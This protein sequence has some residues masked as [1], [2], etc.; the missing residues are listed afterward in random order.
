M[1]KKISKTAVLILVLVGVLLGL[2]WAQKSTQAKKQGWLGIY[3]QELTPELKE[4]MDLK[5]STQG[6]LV[7]GV[8]EDSPAEKAGLE[9]GDVIVSFDG[10]KTRTVETLTSLVRKVAPGT[11]VEIKAIRDGEEK[12]FEVE[13]GESS[14]SGLYNLNPEKLKIE[15]KAIEPFIWSFH[16]GL[17]LGVGIQDL[18]EQLGDYF[19]VKNGEGALITEVEKGS[20]AEKSGLR[21]GDVIVDTDKHKVT[22]AD[23]LREFLS[24]KDKGDKV[25][26]TVIRDRR[27]RDFSVTLVE[28]E[29]EYSFR[30]VPGKGKT[31][32]M[33]LFL[34]KLQVPEVPELKGFYSDQGSLKRD[35]DELKKEMDE[36]KKE[37]EELKDELKR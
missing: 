4:S 32:N 6:V 35:M 3:L 36:L 8:V 21:A 12:T 17:K 20:P 18:T 28:S 9:E 33:E 29:K 14:L 15:K 5:E 34:D 30:M 25:T 1:F 26:L 2:S 13:I 10:R 19:G 16:S 7:N 11:E 37:L 23:D 31:K 24:E 27:P 22:D